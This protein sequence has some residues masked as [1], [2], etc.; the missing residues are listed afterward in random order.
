MGFDC[1]QIDCV[2]GNMRITTTPESR[3]EVTIGN[4]LPSMLKL[5]IELALPIAITQHVSM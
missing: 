2:V 1:D 3:H 4:V 5:L